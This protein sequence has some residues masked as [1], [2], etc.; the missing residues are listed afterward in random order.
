MIRLNMQEAKTHL[1]RYINRVQKGESILLYR[2]NEPVAE[3][4]PQRAR[5]RVRL[6]WRGGSSRFL[7]VSSS[8]C[9]TT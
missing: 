2:R 1:S 6:A 9:P 8:R 4:H 5:S 3:I 7:A